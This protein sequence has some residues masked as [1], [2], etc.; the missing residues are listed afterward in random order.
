D[1]AGLTREAPGAVGHD[2]PLGI[3]FEAQHLGFT[4]HYHKERNG[5]VAHV[6]QHLTARGRVAESVRRD[7][8]NLGR[9]ELRK[10]VVLS[11]LECRSRRRRRRGHASILRRSLSASPE[12]TIRLPWMPLD[13]DTDGRS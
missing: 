10:E 13:A 8:R 3:A 12:G 1:Q 6:D 11:R 5:L 7:A 9:G 2:Q 4:G